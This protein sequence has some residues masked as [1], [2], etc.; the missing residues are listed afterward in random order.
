MIK[1][2]LRKSVFDKIYHQKQTTVFKESTLTQLTSEG[3]DQLEIYF[4]KYIPQFFYAML[5]PLTLFIVVGFMSLKVAL[6]LLLCVHLF[7][8]LLLLYK[9]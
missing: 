1:T 7:L 5:A 3:I 9:K 6:I 2:K 4:S 8:F